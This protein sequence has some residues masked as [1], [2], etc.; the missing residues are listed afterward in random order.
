M[1]TTWGTLPLPSQGST[2]LL[3]IKIVNVLAVI[4]SKF[5]QTRCMGTYPYAF[6]FLSLWLRSFLHA[7]HLHS[8]HLQVS[9]VSI[10]LTQALHVT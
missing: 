6:M 10:S 3:K 5:P 7:T 4:F 9:V 2:A 1:E 8:Q